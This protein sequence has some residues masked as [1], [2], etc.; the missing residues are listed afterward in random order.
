M[1]AL[2]TCRLARR[3]RSI[4]PGGRLRG[5][6]RGTWA[7]RDCN[8][9]IPAGRVVA[10]VGPNGA[11][12][13][14]LLS[15]AA[16]LLRP[17]S[18]DLTVLD[19]CRPGS[20]AA[21]AGLGFVAQDAPLYKHL[22]AADMVRVAASLNS[23]FD[24]DWA[25]ARLNDLRIALRQKIGALS[26]GQRAQLALTLAIAKRP[27]LLLLDEPM[28]AL[29]PLARHEFMALLM[30]AVAEYGPTVVFSSHQLAEL[31][32]V[33]DYLIVL[34]EGRLQ[35]AGPVDD[36][37][38]AHRILIGPVGKISLEAQKF[39]VVQAKQAAAQS[40]LLVRTGDRPAGPRRLAVPA[41]RTLRHRP[42]LPPRPQPERAAKTRA[43]GQCRRRRPV[44]TAAV[45]AGPGRIS[46]V[47]WR[48]HRTGLVAVLGLFGL[49][50]AFMAA[51]ELN[52]RWHADSISTAGPYNLVYPL[53]FLDMTLLP[54]I[55]GLVLGAPMLAHEAESGTVRFAW[56]QDIGKVTL[57]IGKALSVAAGLAV[58]AA[59]LGLE[60]EWWAGPVLKN[61]NHY[62]LGPQFSFHPL[63]YA[64]WTVF[65]FC[66]GLAFGALFRR[67]VPALVV[68]LIGYT[69][70]FYLDNWH[71]RPFYL[72]PLRSTVPWNSVSL[73]FGSG[74]SRE[75]HRPCHYRLRDNRPRRKAD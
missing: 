21:R 14:T 67:T 47:T 39:A 4:G 38:D 70:V 51:T 28:A 24:V 57:L 1:N 10:L 11:G 27:R 16:G 53:V 56:T 20:A 31:E 42:R 63:P 35:V 55:A 33:A 13:T 17:T 71:L 64:A 65:A 52:P 34:N 5:T 69:A 15:I 12:K 32:R 75:S 19:G 18:G 23:S 50:A 62:W 9:V 46:W 43:R 66:L 60:F 25:L 26:A 8:L 58:A 41:R 7:L 74:F 61:L 6:P 30:A 68:T 48:Q 59:G 40:H 36:L 54:V 29:D 73:D 3:Y 37:L 45:L 44:V 72:P 22:P 2:E 49:T